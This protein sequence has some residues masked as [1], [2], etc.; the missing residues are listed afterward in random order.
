MPTASSVFPNLFCTS[1]KVS[2]LILSSLIHF[3]LILVQGDKHVSSFS[4]PHADIQF[5]ACRYTV[6]QATFVEEAV[7]SPLYVFGDFVKN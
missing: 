1:F 5:S 3:E 7:F 2:G 6:F 4:F